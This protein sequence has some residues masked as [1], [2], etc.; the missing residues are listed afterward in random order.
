M[1]NRG[2]IKATTIVYIVIIIFLILFAKYLYCKYNF[3]DYTKGIR[4]AG[5]TSFTR[6]SKIV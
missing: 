4:E 3:Y 1:N 2:K 6:D 5:K